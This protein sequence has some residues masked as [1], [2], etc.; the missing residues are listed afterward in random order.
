LSLDRS[1]PSFIGIASAR[2]LTSDAVPASAAT[3]A[4]AKIKRRNAAMMVM[5]PHVMMMTP[6]VMVMLHLLH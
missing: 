6:Y 1:S 2:V 3:V 4:V 5:G